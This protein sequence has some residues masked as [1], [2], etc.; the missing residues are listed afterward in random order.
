MDHPFKLVSNIHGRCG[1]HLQDQSP[2]RS[3]FNFAKIVE[4]FEAKVSS[5]DHPAIQ[6]KHE[7]G[8]HLGTLLLGS[9]EK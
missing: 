1:H 4:A 8:K 7:H 5:L 2:D 3:L 9:K 6:H